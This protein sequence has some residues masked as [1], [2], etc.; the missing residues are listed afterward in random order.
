MDSHRRF[1]FLQLFLVH[2]LENEI[3]FQKLQLLYFYMRN[4][5]FYTGYNIGVNGRDRF[6]PDLDAGF[7][8]RPPR[9][10]RGIARPH[11]AVLREY[12]AE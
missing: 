5:Y 12:E 3:S 1:K 2:F 6:V 4:S 8:L 10:W 11:V 9:V 7:K